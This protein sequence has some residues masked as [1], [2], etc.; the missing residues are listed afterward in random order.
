MKV[1]VRQHGSVRLLRRL[2]AAAGLQAPPAVRW[3]PFV[4]PKRA[5]DRLHLTIQPHGPQPSTS[6]LAR[7]RC[8]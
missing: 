5:I 1:N 6:P 3:N 8:V 2:M 7:F 4:L